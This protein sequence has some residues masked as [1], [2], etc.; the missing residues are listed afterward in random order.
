MISFKNL[1]LRARLL[2][3]LVTV[4]VLIILVVSGENYLRSSALIKSREEA[5]LENVVEATS[6][7]LEKWIEERFDEVQRWSLVPQFI[8]ACQNQQTDQA[9]LL[10]EKFFTTTPHYENIF[11]A[12]PDGRIF[13]LAA[14]DAQQLKIDISQIPIYAKNAEMSR[15][16]EIYMS[17]AGISPASGRPVSLLTV[18]ITD[19]DGN[20]I[21]IIG[22][23]I[24]LYYVSK[25]F[26]NLHNKGNSE[27]MY[28]ID[29]AGQV[30]GHPDKDYVLQINI[31]DYSWG[32]EML[33]QKNGHHYYDWKGETVFAVFQT[34]PK[35]Q[36]LVVYRINMKE[37]LRPIRQLGLKSLLIGIVSI[38]FAILLFSYIIKQSLHGL[39]M[40]RK[41]LRDIAEGEGDLTQRI[42][43]EWQDEIGK[44]THWFNIFIEKIQKVLQVANS[45]T[46]QIK[47]AS[48]EISAATNEVATGAEEAQSQISE[49]A[50]SIEEMSAMILE[51]SKN[52]SE[53]QTNTVKVDEAAQLGEEIVADIINRIENVAN[54]TQNAVQQIAK[55]E[56]RSRE[57]GDVV[58]VIDDIADQTNLLAL[59]AN[60]EAARAGEAGRGFAVVADE[61]RKLAE[62]TVQSTS[63]I[64]E[65]IKEIQDEV[66]SSVEAMKHIATL[67]S[68]T[69]EVADKTRQALKNI[70]DLTSNVM[71]AITQ[72]ASATDQQSAGAEEI[73]KNIENVATA[74]KQSATSSLEL[75]SSVEELDRE[76]QKLK[77]LI[78]QFKVE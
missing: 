43:Y 20:I 56:E 17:K 31:S 6:S 68:D 37:Y 32:L 46:A 35:T 58:Q 13:L 62:R 59:N 4:M 51:T 65:K 42:H 28:I 12:Y 14:G 9:K 11:L 77:Q 66:S 74:S 34:L 15:K 48:N 30:I 55:L 26:L 76:I 73:S 72:I 22:A 27:Y 41:R 50:A 5:N 53:T 19:S 57:I 70:R 67:S 16:G 40:L 36:W 61:V 7:E 23:P 8:D 47:S 18:P 63:E 64:G 33:G 1:S 69:Q 52:T 71:Q 21:G 38:V 2:W 75:A 24:E 3:L 25:Y 60:I 29:E 45:T 78:E 39:V 44:V 49:I 10:L 54:V